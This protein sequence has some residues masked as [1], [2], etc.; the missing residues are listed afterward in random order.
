MPHTRRQK[1]DPALGLCDLSGANLLE[2]LG[3]VDGLIVAR[4][5]R[6]ASHAAALITGHLVHVARAVKS[7]G[8][9]RLTNGAAGRTPTRLVQQPTTSKELLLSGGEQKLSSAVPA[10]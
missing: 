2:A 1:T 9:L 4:E 8:A 5:E 10:R 7:G 6:H 3:T